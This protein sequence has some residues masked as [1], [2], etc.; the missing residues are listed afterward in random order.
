M[1][2]EIKLLDYVKTN[3]ATWLCREKSGYVLMLRK[4]R[5]LDYVKRNQATWLC[6]EKSD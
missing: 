1:L 6:K 3:Q 2:G 5:L 4:I